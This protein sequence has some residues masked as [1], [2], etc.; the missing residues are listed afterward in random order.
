MPTLSPVSS[1]K[2]NALLVRLFGRIAES[3]VVVRATDDERSWC[4]HDAGASRGGV[5]ASVLDDAW[6]RGCVVSVA[7]G[8]ATSRGVSGRSI[9]GERGKGVGEGEGSSQSGLFWFFNWFFSRVERHRT[10]EFP[11]HM[12]VLCVV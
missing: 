11:T 4:S 1:K 7:G 5:I 12:V 6:H 8:V 3:C 10:G 9:R 2:S